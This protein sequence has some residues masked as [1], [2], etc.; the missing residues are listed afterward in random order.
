MQLL[1]IENGL[2]MDEAL[3]L[4]GTGLLGLVGAFLG[5]TRGN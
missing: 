3:F 1:T 2:I 4:S 5:A